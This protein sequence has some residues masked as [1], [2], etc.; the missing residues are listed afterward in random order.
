MCNFKEWNTT[1]FGPFVFMFKMLQQNYNSWMQ[2][3]S[4]NELDFSWL[5]W[6]YCIQ[7]FQ[8]WQTHLIKLSALDTSA[9]NTS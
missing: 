5:R 3:Q 4:S 1:F 8:Q 9:N 6:K 2:F 7:Q